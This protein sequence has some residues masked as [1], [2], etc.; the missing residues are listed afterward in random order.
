MKSSSLYERARGGERG[1][2]SGERG[3]WREGGRVV[4]IVI[5]VIL[6]RLLAFVNVSP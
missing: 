5:C 2:V 1:G 6:V 3:C 4:V